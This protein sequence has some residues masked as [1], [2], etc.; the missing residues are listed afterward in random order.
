MPE[1]KFDLSAAV[2]SVQQ[3][4][5]N[6]IRGEYQKLQARFREELI[7]PDFD[8]DR[9]VALHDEIVRFERSTPWVKE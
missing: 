4:F 8:W 2:Y 3:S 6:L 1:K 7:S 9:L 5:L